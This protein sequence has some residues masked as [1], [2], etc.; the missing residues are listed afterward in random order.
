MSNRSS[1]KRA[2]RLCVTWDTSL[3]ILIPS[4]SAISISPVRPRGARGNWKKCSS[5]TKCGRSCAPGAATAR[6][7]L[8]D[9]LDLKKIKAHPK[10]FV[11]YSDLTTLLTYFADA[12]GLITFHGP[13][14]AKDFAH[15]DGVDRSSW[16]RAL[17]G[18]SEWVLELEPDVKSLVAGVWGRNSLRR[19]P[20]H[21]GGFVGH[22]L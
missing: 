11:G 5:A 2:A 18:S 15:A 21:S 6:T 8:L 9:I 16:E 19:M 12:T 1:W 14:V 20:F 4:S 13:M 3:S 22:A 7:I 10:I 17:N